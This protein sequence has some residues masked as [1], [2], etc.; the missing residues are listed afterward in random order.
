MPHQHFEISGM[1]I[2]RPTLLPSGYGQVIQGW[3]ETAFHL[4]PPW[5]QQ[6]DAV[7]FCTASKADIPT[8][9][10]E[11]ELKQEVKSQLDKAD[12]HME[13]L[14]ILA[15]KLDDTLSVTTSIPLRASHAATP[16]L[17]IIS[18]QPHHKAAPDSASDAAV[19]GMSIKD[20]LRAN[21]WVPAYVSSTGSE[22]VGRLDC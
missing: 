9:I 13:H 22:E 21:G 5:C 11:E 20:W 7:R 15:Q 16:L 14:K 18:V 8:D 4:Q 6:T 10:G 17:S 12:E 1:C 19:A 3:S 2:E